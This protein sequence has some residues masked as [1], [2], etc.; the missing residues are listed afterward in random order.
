M[1]FNHSYYVESEKFCFHLFFWR[2]EILMTSCLSVARCF[3]P[4]VLCVMK[5][6]K[7]L[8]IF[9]WIV[10]LAMKFWDT[11]LSCFGL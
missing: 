10:L 9:F 4:C 1:F 6:L 3:L 8:I 7:L 11:S 5:P 2:L